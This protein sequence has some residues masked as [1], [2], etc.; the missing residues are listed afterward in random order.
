MHLTLM[1]LESPGSLE[2]RWGWGIFMEMGCGMEE[3]LDVEQMEGGW[4]VR[5]WN[6]ECKKIYKY[7]K[8]NKK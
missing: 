3:D 1:R 7:N 8:I 2:V 6:I 4:G 5:E